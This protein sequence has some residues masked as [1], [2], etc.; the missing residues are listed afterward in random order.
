MAATLEMMLSINCS[1]QKLV[2]LKEKE[3]EM[4]ESYQKEK[5]KTFDTVQ[6][7]AQVNIDTLMKQF[8]GKL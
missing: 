7:A 1:L 3:L 5:L 2:D 6:K 8:S 4:T